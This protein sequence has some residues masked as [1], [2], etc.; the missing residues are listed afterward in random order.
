MERWVPLFEIFMNS[1]CPETEASLWLQKSF[2]FSSF[3]SISTSSFISL[4]T[5]SSEVVV[6]N[7]ATSSESPSST[8]TKRFMYLQTLPNAVQARILSFLVYERRRFCKRDLIELARRML[9]EG[10]EVDFWVKKAAHQLF[11]VLSGSGFEWISCLDL[12]SEEECVEDKFRAL[13]DWLQEAAADRG[14]LVLPWLPLLPEEINVGRPFCN[15]QDDED[16]ENCV[17]IAKQIDEDEVMGE[18][19]ADDQKH[20]MDH[21]VD[22][23]AAKLKSQILNFE[24]TSKTIELTND[25]RK[26]CLTSKVDSSHIMTFIEPWKADDETASIMIANLLGRDA[27]EFGWPSQIL[28]SVVLPKLLALEVPASRILVSA[29]VEF[30]KRHQKATEYALL[31]PLLLKVDGINNSIC[32]VVTRIVRECLHP[33][34]VSAFC[35]KLL[36]EELDVKNFTCLPCHRSL[37][38]GELVWTE[39]LFYLMQNILN[40]NVPLTQDTVDKLVQEVCKFATRFPKSLKLGNFCLCFVNKCAHLLRPHKLM[41][42]ETVEHT[43]T[44]VT[45]SIM[46]KLTSL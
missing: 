45:K 18:A 16:S 27:D 25:L 31:F 5:S 39:S 2:A 19:R 46:S 30:C 32:D 15:F 29:T 35:R 38:A 14:D 41:L 4:L 28:C 24:T 40:H 11:D 36:C 10:H 21:E 13:P 23:M 7:S 33:A 43:S 20:V 26:L 22:M 9:T 1:P 42:M 44:L 6:V 17:E 37:I 34:H 8:H 3:P 12:D